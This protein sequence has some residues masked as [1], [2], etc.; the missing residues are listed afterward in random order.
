MSGGRAVVLIDGG[1]LDHVLKSCDVRGDID[2]DQLIHALAQ[3]AI[4]KEAFY[5]HC[6]HYRP[7]NPTEEDRKRQ[8]TSDSF[9]DRLE[10][11]PSLTVRYG[12]PVHRGEK[13]DGQ[14]IPVQKQVDVLLAVEIVRIALRREA[15]EIVLVTGDSDLLPALRI[16]RDE[17][18]RIRLAHGTRDDRPHGELRELAHASHPLDRARF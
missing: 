3:P 14:P 17:G 10:R 12:K 1:Y 8:A 16:A 18:I 7:K 9:L 15:P 6:R 4:L 13:P 11:V 2:Y 5:Y